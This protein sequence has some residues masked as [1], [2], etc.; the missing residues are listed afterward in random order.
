[1]NDIVISLD[2]DID[3]YIEIFDTALSK[4]WR[5]H[6]EY[7]IK[8]Q[9][10]LE[11]NYC[12]LGFNNSSRNGEFICNQINL[13]LKNITENTT[14]KINDYFKIDDIISYE[15]IINRQEPNQE[16]L[17]KLHFYFEELQ[18]MRNNLS[19]FY[20][21]SSN[22][23]KYSIRQLNLLCHE[24][25]SWILSY[26]KSIRKPEWIRPSQ[27]MC[28][29]NSTRFELDSEHYDEFGLDKL[30]RKTGGVYLGLNKSV[31]KTHYEVFCDERHKTDNLTTIAMR[32]QFVGSADFDIEWGKSIGPT[33]DF[34]TKEIEQFRN[35]LF[36]IGENP[37]DK[38]L[39]VG[40]P[41]LAQVNLQK[42]FGTTDHI[43]IRKIL[44][45]GLN[46]CRILFNDLEVIYKYR[47]NDENYA[48]EQMKVLYEKNLC[49]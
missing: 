4:T 36:D 11:K 10:H 6:L 9:Y 15:M 27:L 17:N 41:Q 49:T 12:F 3:I 37:D 30:Y 44:E 42:S 29:L 24:L 21:N 28:W 47:W 46:V 38:F 26:R 43:E 39:G 40:Y 20:L 31:G 33:D 1:M 2:N 23:V 18:G 25:E 7:I 13:H 14:Y 48:F 34:K 19:N 32:P 5:S 22:S 8:K 35:W 16:R 45:T